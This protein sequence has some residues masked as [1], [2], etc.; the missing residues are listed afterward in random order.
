VTADSEWAWWRERRRPAD[1]V[2]LDSAAAGRSSTATLAAT[3]AHAEREATRGAY[4]AQAEAAG[5]LDAGR[6]ELAGLLG[7]PAAGLAFTES[8]ALMFVKGVGWRLGGRGSGFVGWCSDRGLLL[9]YG[10]DRDG[11]P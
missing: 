2:H 8:D 5:A 11:R 1:L 7:V 6:A 10:Q 9:G 3:A 4:V